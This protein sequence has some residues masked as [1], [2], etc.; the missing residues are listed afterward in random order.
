MRSRQLCLAIAATLMAAACGE[1]LRIPQAQGGPLG[2]SVWGGQEAGLV[3]T[4]TGA[5]VQFAC[6]VG[7]ISVAIVRDAAGH[8]RVPGIYALTPGPAYLPHPATYDGTVIGD[9]MALSVIV[10]E[11]SAQPVGP[12]ALARGVPFTGPV[13]L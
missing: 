7:T 8:F 10:P 13:C 5:T 6:A 11:V 12:F 2:P 1:S 3:V 9:A 4:D